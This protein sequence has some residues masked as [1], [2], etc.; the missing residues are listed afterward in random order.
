MIPC[1]VSGAGMFAGPATHAFK[2]LVIEW[3]ESSGIGYDTRY[4]HYRAQFPG[5]EPGRLAR[6]VCDPIEYYDREW[7]LHQARGDAP[8]AALLAQ[9]V[10]ERDACFR[11]EARAAIYCFDE[12][13]IGS[14]INVMRFLQARKP[15]FGFYAAD[16]ARRRINLTN[17]LQLELEFPERVRLAAYETPAD[18]TGRLGDW[19]PALT[20]PRAG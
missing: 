9:F 18:V 5:L 17:V 8:D 13:G 2:T 7:T 3:L 19:L 1:Y 20:S 15:V 12:A 11:A 10:Q 4:R 6:L 14:G 16:P